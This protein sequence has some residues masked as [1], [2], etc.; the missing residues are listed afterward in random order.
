MLDH[1]G[2]T[3]DV[4][5]PPRR[6]SSQVSGPQSHSQSDVHQTPV[7]DHE[8]SLGPNASRDDRILVGWDGDDDQ[9]N[10][11][12]WS[13]LYKSWITFQ[14]GMLALSASLGSSIISPAG[15]RL[16]HWGS[17]LDH[18]AG[19]QYLSF[20]EDVGVCY[21]IILSGIVLHW[22]SYKYQRGVD[23]HNQILWRII[24]IGT[25]FECFCS[26]GD[27]WSP[28][29][30]G[31]AVTFYAV[32]VVGGPTLGPLIGSALL[33]NPH[34]G[35]RWTEYLEA[36]WVFAM[37]GLC[38]ICLPEVYT[39][40]LLKK[41]AARLRKE[42]GNNA[43]YHPHE[44]IKLD[45]KTIV[46]KHFSRPLLMLTTEPMVTCI[47]FYASFVY[48]ILY[49]TLEVFPIVFSDNRGWSPVI[50]S[51]PFLGLF[52]GVNLA[53]VVNLG[54][55]PRY[56]RIVDAAGGRPVPE[57]RLAPWHSEELY[58]QSDFFASVFIGAGF[59]IIF[60]Q[61]I[62]FLVDTYALYAASAVSANTFLRSIFATGFPLAAG[63]MF[64]AMG[65]GPAMS[66]LGGVATV[67]IPVPFL[68]MKYGVTLRKKSKF[69]PYKD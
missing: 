64:R 27:M 65:V 43:Y 19:H 32:A 44:E 54:N 49:L 28:K 59:N 26:V 56:A 3:T 7:S 62:N 45:A 1:D 16:R 69:A 21:P 8:K 47:A 33:V 51:L 48:A 24:W 53:V 29:A 57:A 20:G 68:F 31:T 14:L 39:P 61:C 6:P 67:A 34:L 30:R 58:S 9:G 10:P 55:Q 35:W 41:K 15:K 36:I 18:F 52:V 66:V 42:T 60:Q 5:T 40:V 13:T 37:F 25:C 23:L 46:T 22:N 50:A 38:F 63:P 2:E 11:R 4:E 17:H 12:N